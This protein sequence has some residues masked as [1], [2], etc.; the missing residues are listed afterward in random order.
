MR[1]E[2]SCWRTVAWLA[3]SLVG[4]TPLKSPSNGADDGP[5]AGAGAHG[6]DASGEGGGAGAEDGGD[7]ADG[8]RP[9]VEVIAAGLD[10]ARVVAVDDVN[11]YFGTAG[12]SPVVATCVKSG[13]VGAPRIL[14]SGLTRSIVLVGG[15]VVWADELT[16]QVLACAPTGCTSPTVL[17]SG[18]VGVRAL[19][20]DGAD[21]FWS[22]AAGMRRCTPSSCTPVSIRDDLG[23]PSAIALASGS[24]ASQALF[25]LD[26]SDDSVRRCCALDCADV[27]KIG[28]GARGLTALGASVYW[29]SP[30]SELLRFD[31]SGC[32]PGPPASPSVLT[33][34]RTPDLPV[35]DARRIYYRDRGTDDIAEQIATSGYQPRVLA[36]AEGGLPGANLALDGLHVYWTTP[37]AVRRV[38][39]DTSQF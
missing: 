13:C 29:V 19:T 3:L 25:F 5:D 22:T 16:G 17:A 6:E 2:R 32:T 34:F 38:L 10:A 8:G 21:L 36:A 28:D 7:S 35:A 26:G 11:V 23:S 39:R 33:T 31:H 1:S 14:G 18:Q 20:T 4:C 9:V 37:S 12:A 15:Q 27:A 24:G 30:A